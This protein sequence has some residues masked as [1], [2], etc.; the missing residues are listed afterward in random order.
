SDRFIPGRQLPD[1]AMDLVD[2]AASRLRMELDS[3]PVEI[4]SLRRQVDRLT[5]EELTL[6]EGI[7]AEDDDAAARERLAK[8]RQ[9]LA[10]KREELASL[11]ARWEAEKAGHNRVGDLKA[12]LDELR[13][14]AEKA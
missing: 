13:V 5:M 11:T 8:I 7:G 14:A 2:E 4:D 10:N 3:S 9:D 1:K 6:A 12:R